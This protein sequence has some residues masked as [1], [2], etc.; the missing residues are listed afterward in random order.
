[1]LG[2]GMQHDSGTTSQTV[3]QHAIGGQVMK[4]F[5]WLYGLRWFDF[6]VSGEEF[7]AEIAILLNKQDF[8]CRGF[9]LK[10]K[11]SKKNP[12]SNIWGLLYS[13]RLGYG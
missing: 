11:L 1:M 6:R 9:S 8:F 2:E 4:M 12:Q 10:T 13:N 5:D 7:G 3:E